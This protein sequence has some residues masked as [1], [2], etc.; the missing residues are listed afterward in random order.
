VSTDAVLGSWMDPGLA[1]RYGNDLM[2]A[3]LPGSD[4]ATKAAVDEDPVGVGN[5]LRDRVHTVLYTTL[6]TNLFD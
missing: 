4:K 6:Q 3:M 5:A 2:L 1:A